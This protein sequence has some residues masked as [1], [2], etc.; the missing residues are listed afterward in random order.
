MADALFQVPLREDNY[1]NSDKQTE[2]VS[3]MQ[4]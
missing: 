2:V 4:L 3:F 1:K